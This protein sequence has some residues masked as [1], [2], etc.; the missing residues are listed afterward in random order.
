VEA[1]LN[2]SAS[3]LHWTRRM[4]HVRKS[5]P[6][7]GRGEFTDLGGSNPSILS[8][9]RRL[10]SADGG[11]PDLILCVNNLSRFPQAVRLDLAE[12]AGRQ[13]VELTGGVPFPGVD[14]DP[15]QLTLPGYGF[16]WLELRSPTEGPS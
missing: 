3:L 7:F 1:Q 5:H 10:E 9:L 16:Y 15:Y 6:A 8:Y 4:I 2:S 11:E 12:F 13:P 14:A